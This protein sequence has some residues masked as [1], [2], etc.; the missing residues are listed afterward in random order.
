MFRHRNPR[1]TS[2]RYIIQRILSGKSRA[3]TRLIRNYGDKIREK[4]SIRGKSR[5]DNASRVAW[6]TLYIIALDSAPFNVAAILS[7]F[8]MHR[9]SW[10]YSYSNISCIVTS[11]AGRYRGKSMRMCSARNWEST[12]GRYMTVWLLFNQNFKTLG[13]ETDMRNGLECRHR[14][15]QDGGT[16]RT[17]YKSGDMRYIWPKVTEIFIGGRSKFKYVRERERRRKI[18]IATNE[19]NVQIVCRINAKVSRRGVVFKLRSRRAIKIG[20]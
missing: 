11:L 1:Q 12:G 2:C 6:H 10:R 5:D 18:G 17:G 14:E 3:N 8:E 19:E 13:E 16:G 15:V 7:L 9:S 4:V 20:C